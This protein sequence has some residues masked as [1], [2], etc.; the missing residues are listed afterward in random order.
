MIREHCPDL[1]MKCWPTSITELDGK[2]YI[3]A[4]DNSEATHL[5]MY[6]LTKGKWSH[7]PALPYYKCSLVAVCSKKQLLAIGGCLKTNDVVEVSGQVFLWE[8]DN[9]KWVVNYPSMPTARFS[10]SSISHGLMVIVAGGVM[11]CD[12]WIMTSVVEILSVE[13]DCSWFSP[14]NTHWVKVE[15]LPYTVYDAIPLIVHDNIYIIGG[16]DKQHYSHSTCKVVM[17]SLS[18][19]PKSNDTDIDQMWSRLPDMP[20]SAFS[21]N[22]YQGRLI[23]FTG[24]S[25]AEQ[26]DQDKLFH[27]FHL[28]NPDTKS[29]DYVANACEGYIWG[30]SV[31]ISEDVIFV[32]GGTTGTIYRGKDDNLVKMCMKLSI[33][34]SN[35][36]KILHDAF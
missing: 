30:R 31:H 25:L 11:C 5:Y 4:Q 3:I 21:V 22:H 35:K 34:H 20:Y 33:V 15:Q 2:V 17:A 16:F 27:Q 8:E 36:K 24:V 28:Y 32:V 26:P 23:T 29:W 14:H 7:L 10:S 18:E 12:P 9:A 19:L 1:L 13:E 6:D